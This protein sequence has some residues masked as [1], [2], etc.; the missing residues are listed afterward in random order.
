MGGECCWFGWEVEGE[1]MAE[2]GEKCY[3]NETRRANI[4]IAMKESDSYCGVNSAVN[5]RQQV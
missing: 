3:R 5:Q 4:L 1:R 2:G